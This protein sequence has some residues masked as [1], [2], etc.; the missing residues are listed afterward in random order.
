MNRDYWRRLLS[1][2]ASATLA[3]KAGASGDRELRAR[4]AI[5]AAFR[6][7]AEGVDNV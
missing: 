1:E 5:E 6:R 4:L 2:W 3:K 7:E